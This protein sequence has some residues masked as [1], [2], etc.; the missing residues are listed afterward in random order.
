M[1][2]LNWHY[3]IELLL[4]QSWNLVKPEKVEFLDDLGI[5]FLEKMLTKIN[6]S[7]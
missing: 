7:Q 4:K 6:G 3:K 5:I 2:K 1:A